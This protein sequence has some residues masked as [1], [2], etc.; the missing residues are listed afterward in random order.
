MVLDCF[1][2][3][4]VHVYT[5]IKTNFDTYKITKDQETVYDL[6]NRKQAE[7]YMK[8]LRIIYL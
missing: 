4:K 2:T 5:L 1:V 3:K 6:L 7:I 8:S